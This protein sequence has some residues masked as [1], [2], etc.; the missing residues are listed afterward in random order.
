MPTKN[1]KT[2][3]SSKLKPEH[4]LSPKLISMDIL[5]AFYGDCFGVALVKSKVTPGHISFVIL[6]EDDGSW[7]VASG[8]QYDSYWLPEL[9]DVMKEAHRWLKNN[10]KK[11]EW[12]WDISK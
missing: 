9:I 2:S 5:V 7:N 11:T 8:G 12:G 3:V 1:S 6:V 10:A 4:E